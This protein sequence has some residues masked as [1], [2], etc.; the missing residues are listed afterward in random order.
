MSATWSRS[1][2]TTS[3]SASPTH[4]KRSTQRRRCAIASS[5][6][7]WRRV[8]RRRCARRD[9][10]ST[11]S[12]P[13]AT[14]CWSSTATRVNGA[15]GV[16]GTYR[17]MR[18]SVARRP[19][20]LLFGPGIRP[21][22]HSLS[23]APGEMVE[24]GRSC[25]ELGLSQPRCHADAVARPRRLRVRAPHPPD[26]RLRQ[27]SRHRAGRH[28]QAQLSYLHHYHLAPQAL[29]PRALAHHYVPMGILPLAGFDAT[30][31]ARAACRR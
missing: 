19:W 28:W 8:R 4:R 18:R 30:G 9:A 31:G 24:L 20:R 11:P 14:I 25:V 2:T 6:R 23:I 21:F 5:T 27:L 7:R 15:D 13:S 29:R 1:S 3:R 16:V 26:V 12:M 10:T 22:A 17:L